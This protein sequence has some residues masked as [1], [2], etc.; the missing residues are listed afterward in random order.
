MRITIDSI[1]RHNIVT[2]LL[3]LPQNYIRA[4]GYGRAKLVG[5]LG[6]DACKYRM[7]EFLV[8]TCCCMY[9]CLC[10][11][12]WIY[13][14]KYMRVWECLFSLHLFSI[15]YINFKF[16]FNAGLAG[17]WCY[18]NQEIFLCYFKLLNI[19]KKYHYS[20]KK[21]IENENPLHPIKTPLINW[22]KLFTNI[23]SKFIKQNYWRF[24]ELNTNEDFI[25]RNL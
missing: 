17:S 14:Y 19:N 11:C 13:V 23:F 10:S 3:L 12:V 18:F 15:T 22:K 24:F 16:L 21:P 6:P 4:V 7:H 9:V 5:A 20:K 8:S 2:Q 1:H 25:E